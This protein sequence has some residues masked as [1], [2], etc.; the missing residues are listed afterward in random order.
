MTIK[1]QLLALAKDFAFRMQKKNIA[2]YAGS[3][4]YFLMI[5]IVPL[6]IFI[7]SLL[8][9]TALTASDLSRA[10]TEITPDFADDITLRLIS[11]AYEQSVAV[12]S[13]SA[14]ATIWSGALGMMSI[15]RGLNIIYDLE[16]RR[17]Y[18]YLRA[19]AALYTMAM[20]VIV[21]V[22]LL[23]MVF[24][25]IV[26]SIAISHFPGIMFLIS[27]SSYFKFI[28]VILVATFLFAM[29]Y[30]FVP[31]AKMTFVYQIP[32]AVFSAVVWYIFS[33]LF[34]LYV[35][36]SGYFSVYG[37]IATLMI[38]MIWLYF[39]IYIF[40][41]GAFINRFFHPAVKVLYDDHHQ[42]KVRERVKKKS[43]R[44]LRKPR[45]YNEFG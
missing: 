10:L 3:C 37:S 8:P 4:A 33:W 27:L 44:Q 22:M 32:G 16:E 5:S 24:E 43:Q 17:N 6:L 11:E 18:F 2:A 23:F 15:I 29:I 35:D 7:S 20:I 42:S 25:R 13:I 26:K 40:M 28:V 9:Y 14:L 41:I 39:C 31:S 1:Q 19:I 45:K 12:F 36:L 21:M 38:M 30:T 34:S